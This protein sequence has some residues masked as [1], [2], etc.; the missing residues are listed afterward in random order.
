MPLVQMVTAADKVSQ[1][2][3]EI[4][5]S[6]EELARAVTADREDSPDLLV[7]QVNRALV[8]SLEIADLPVLMDPSEH[9]V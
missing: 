3:P 8:D 9:Q 7:S 2:N 5:V 4:V 1:V 6:A